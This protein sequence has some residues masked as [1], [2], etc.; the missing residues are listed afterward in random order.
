MNLPHSLL[1]HL[2][3]FGIDVLRLC[4][5]LALLV[6]V[7]GPIER[8]FSLREAGA[9]KRELVHNL[10]YY[11]LNSLLPAFLLALPT[12]LLAIAAQHAMPA[13]FFAAVQS[14]PAA[15]KLI[16]VFVVG[17]TGFYWGHRL[18]HQIPF[19]WRF[20]SVH[21]SAEHLYFLINTRAHPIDMVITRLFG[22]APLYILGLAGAGAGGAAA[23]IMMILT[24]TVWGF[25]IHS[26]WRVRLGPLEWLVATPAF[27]H[28]H[29][30]RVDHIN[31]NYA[32]MLPMIDRL[33]GTH[34]LPREWPADYGLE[35]AYPT[36][37]TAQ[38]LDPL[39]PGKTIAQPTEPSASST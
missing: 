24:G 30:S 38:L 15:V 27:H 32:S 26:N 5:W 19:L 20:H 9:G 6:A 35:A 18:S 31:R 3:A 25:F 37:L 23:P 4:L 22:L 8:F 12:S 11:F 36:T 13:A 34:H 17:E 21:H 33:F 39:L 29:H 28:W 7:F 10:C 2:P 1:A 16:L 14:L